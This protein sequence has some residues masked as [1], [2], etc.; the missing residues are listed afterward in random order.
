MNKLNVR[1]INDI[2]NVLEFYA[3]KDNY[4]DGM[5]VD[6]IKDINGDITYVEDLGDKANEL[7]KRLREL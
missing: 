2:L 3:N 5:I 6:K 7:L 1:Q 4:I